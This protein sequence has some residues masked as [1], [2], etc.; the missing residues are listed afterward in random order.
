MLTPLFQR[1]GLNKYNVVIAFAAMML[2]LMSAK[3]Q[4]IDPVIILSYKADMLGVC[5]Y[6][7]PHQ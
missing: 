3:N 4:K 1:G 7:V 6:D 5:F 2:F